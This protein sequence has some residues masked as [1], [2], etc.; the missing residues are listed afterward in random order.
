MLLDGLASGLFGEVPDGMTSAA[1]AFSDPVDAV[2]APAGYPAAERW[3]GAL[4]PAEH[5]DPGDLD[6]R[7][8]GPVY[9][10]QGPEPFARSLPHVQPSGGGWVDVAP[11]MGHDGPQLPWDSAAG[12]PFLGSGP[13][14]PDLHGDDTGGVWL[15]T[16]AV[17]AEIGTLA[18]VTIPAEANDRLANSQ[19]IIGQT[20][21][22]GRTNLD[23]Q[24]WHDPD[25]YGP[26]TIPY[27]ERPLQNNVAFEAL[28]ILPT[29]SV[30][31]PSGA[32]PDR[33]PVQ[34]YPAVVYEPP[35]DPQT[36]YARSPAT[37]STPGG[38]WVLG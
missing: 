34:S 1:P 6:P 25:G 29:D 38:G 16:Y 26:W 33:S 31:T 5:T 10:D 2:N 7:F 4:D 9:G 13:V 12:P 36:V 11:D 21:A 35:A 28:P 23:Q 24:Q 27:A 14:N 3:P 18:R 22:A 17:P 20:Q 32:L 8:A 37:A 30:Y 15:K 19:E